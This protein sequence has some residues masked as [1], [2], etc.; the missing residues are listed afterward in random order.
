MSEG[1]AKRSITIR[2]HRTSISLE[3]GFWHELRAIAAERR[4]TLTALITA[5]DEQ[6]R[7]ANLSSALRLAVLDHLRTRTAVT[8]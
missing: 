1:I 5:I 8:G 2:G 6:R 7:H 3:D 4:M